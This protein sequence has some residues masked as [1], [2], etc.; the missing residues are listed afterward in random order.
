MGKLTVDVEPKPFG[1]KCN[2]PEITT[3]TAGSQADKKGVKVG[4]IVLTV[5]GNAVK[6]TADVTKGLANAKKAGKKYKI[7]ME[8][9]DGDGAAA[10]LKMG[11]KIGS[12]NGGGANGKVTI[13]VEPKPF[14]VKCNG[15]TVTDVTAGSQAEKAGVK[16]GWT[17]VEIGGKKVSTTPEITKALADNKKKGKKYKI[18]AVNPEATTGAD[19]GSAVSTKEATAEGHKVTTVA[20]GAVATAAAPAEPGAEGGTDEVLD[21]A[22]E[23][24]LKRLAEEAE[25][26]RIFHER[27][28]K[29]EEARQSRLTGKVILKYEMYAEEFTIKDG[30]LGGDTD[31]GFKEGE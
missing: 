30:R 25:R 19:S 8:T 12:K 14:G 17:I 9:P 26:T 5:A 27:L 16:V 21:P 4:W 1:I 2:G 28:A 7:E 3:V 18:I 15:Q 20:E 23:E 11:S 13:D 24:E 22:L 6:T 10:V 31:E 29:I